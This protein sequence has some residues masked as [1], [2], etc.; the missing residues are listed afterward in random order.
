ME[1]VYGLNANPTEVER[2]DWN[3]HNVWLPLT[4][5]R[6]LPGHILDHLLA[7]GRPPAVADIATGTGIWLKSLATQLPERSRLDGFDF[8]TT[9]FHPPS[10]LPAGVRL[11]FGNAFEPFPE[12]LQETYDLVHVRLLGSGLRSEQWALVANNLRTLLRPGGYLFWED[13]T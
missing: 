4:G 5:G 12:K 2:L 10:E 9:K 7:L 11:Q 8:V 13:V 3:H 6:L 1:S